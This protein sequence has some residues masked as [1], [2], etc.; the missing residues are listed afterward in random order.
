MGDAKR[1]S[2]SKRSFSSC[3]SSDDTS[4]SERRKE[5]RHKKHRKKHDE[6]EDEYRHSKDRSKKSRRKKHRTKSRSERRDRDRKRKRRHEYGSSSSDEDAHG[7]QNADSPKCIVDSILRK[8][9]DA[10]HDLKQLLQMIDNGQAVDIN[11]IASNTLSRLLKKLFHSL[12][13]KRSGNGVY[14][15]PAGGLPCIEAVGASLENGGPIASN[16]GQT[17]SDKSG[18][19]GMQDKEQ[20][21]NSGS[22]HVE[23]VETH[24]GKPDCSSPPKRRMIGPAMPSREMLAAAAK[25]TEAEKA[26]REAEIE[27]EDDVLIGPPP[28]AA[29]AEAES[30][31]DAERFEEV[32]RIISLEASNPYEILGL[33]KGASSEA[34]K[35]RYWKLS[36]LVHPDKC[37]HPQAHQCFTILNQAFKD[38]QDPAK[39]EVID[40][41]ISKQEEKDEFEAHLKACREAAQWR[42]LRGEALP[43]DDEL[44]GESKKVPARDEWMTTLPPERK[45]GMSMHSTFFSKSEKTGRGD[46]SVWTDTPSEK[47]Q[48]AKQHYLEAYNQAAQ[49]L[50]GSN[51][52][53]LEKEQRS[54]T[55]KLMDVYNKSKR[56]M[57]LV[58]KH[59][60][61]KK[62][63]KK[64]NKD[65]KPK[66]TDEEW[67]GKHPWR[68]WNRETDLAA[69]RQTVKFDSQSMAKGLSSR[70]SSG[71]VQRSFL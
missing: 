20:N 52:N 2:K 11:E 17:V 32:A 62:K 54:A 6:S 28:P 51:I 49:S 10:R 23:G 61:Q 41:D 57:S 60:E 9:P 1:S 35:K 48:K 69:G 45:A 19:S 24:E 30:A 7:N 22:I 14:L 68:P 27:L 47:A 64:Q 58:E 46:T 12:R 38:L 39:R 63:V 43:G 56:S 34:T 67:V 5:R 55:A 4:E 50:E 66:D 18:T 59:Q 25:L 70:F 40:A 71:S 15:L 37:S 26:L 44:L 36:L 42:H 33:N 53:E 8:F 21:K 29:V 31:N 65:K 3:T 16:D 13:L